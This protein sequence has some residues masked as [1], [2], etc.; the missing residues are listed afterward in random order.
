MDEIKI[1]G[2]IE[3]IDEQNKQYNRKFTATL[4]NAPAFSY[5][6]R[7]AVEIEWGKLANGCTIHSEW[8]DTRYDT[9]IRRNER[10]FKK[11]VQNYFANNFNAHVLTLY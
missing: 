3:F 7:T 4:T 9:T 1:K 11:W 8:I 10:D 6:N 2:K 5:G